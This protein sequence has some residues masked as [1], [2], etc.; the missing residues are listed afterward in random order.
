MIKNV[1]I[2]KR[3]KY[4]GKILK[5]KKWF[6]ELRYSSRLYYIVFKFIIIFSEFEMDITLFKWIQESALTQKNV[7]CTCRKIFIF[8]LH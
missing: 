6:K 1:W 5:S 7:T 2:N 8:H 4:L 3:K